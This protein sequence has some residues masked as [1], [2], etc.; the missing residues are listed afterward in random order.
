MQVRLLALVRYINAQ[1]NNNKVVLF[2]RSSCL[3]MQYLVSDIYQLVLT[4]FF[5]FK[6]RFIIEGRQFSKSVLVQSQPEHLFQGPCLMLRSYDVFLLPTFH[7]P[8]TL[9]TIMVGYHDLNIL[10]NLLC[11]TFQD[12]D[13]HDIVRP[14]NAKHSMIAPHFER[15]KFFAEVSFM[16]YHSHP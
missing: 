13:I 7:S 14:T 15:S 2:K 9:A 11:H 16:V 6:C 12:L 8:V 5:F 4:H 10:L 1:Q 3:V